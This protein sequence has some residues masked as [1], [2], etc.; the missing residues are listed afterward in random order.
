MDIYRIAALCGVLAAC[1]SAADLPPDEATELAEGRYGLVVLTHEAGEP[2][3][4]VSGQLMSW[5]GWTR[6]EALHALAL[7]EQAWLLAPRGEGCAL[8]VVGGE[9]ELAGASIDLL[10]AGPLRVRS[11]T[12]SL[13][14]QPRDF[15]SVLFALSG[16]VY[17]A[18]APELPFGD[19]LYRVDAPGDE[20]G[21][22]AGE[23]EAPPALQIEE[24]T[25]DA[26]GLHVT[27]SGAR[28]TTVMLSRDRGSRTIGVVCSASEQ[29]LTVP[30]AALRQ[31]GVGPAQL[32]VAKTQRAALR[33][34]ELD[35][36][37]LLFVSR[38]TREVR[39]RKEPQ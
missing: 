9:P 24:L 30:P 35:E 39:I 32:V 3:V 7:P 4:A 5:R 25:Q 2:G 14:L 1:S 16:V 8:R 37:H 31:L 6:S 19:A 10:S 20:L 21:A 12:Q 28:R 26:S 23:V 13:E 38:D 11:E 29:R 22:L 36:A 18:D 15:P 34:A 33:S 17:D 27:W